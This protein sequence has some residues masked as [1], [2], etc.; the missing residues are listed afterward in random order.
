MGGSE[1]TAVG[2]VGS[3]NFMG[4]GTIPGEKGAKEL[5]TGRAILAVGWLHHSLKDRS[6][7]DGALGRQ[8]RG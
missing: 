7:E 6:S 4:W 8:R 3:L 5:R 2:R 1:I